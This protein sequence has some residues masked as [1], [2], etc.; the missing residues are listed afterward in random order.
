MISEKYRVVAKLRRN[1]ARQGYD[2]DIITGASDRRWQPPARAPCRIPLLVDPEDPSRRYPIASLRGDRRGPNG[3]T[4]YGLRLWENE[5]L[6]PRPDDVFQERLYC[7]RWVTPS[8]E[9][10]YK[11]VTDA[12][13]A[14]EAKV[15]ALLKQRF[16][17]W[18]A[19][20][21]IPS[22]KITPGYNT[23]Q[24]IRE[25]GWTY[26]H[27][28]F[29]PRQLLVHGLLMEGMGKLLSDDLRKH[30]LFS[31]STIKLEF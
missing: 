3:E 23:E 25:R 28:L 4:I 15:L 21:Y 22:M 9:R 16:A 11:S 24:P 19:R 2:I 7:V 27:H 14:R 26:W 8:G 10:V 20:G 29:N 13:I 17:D 12:D 6:V 1:D 5:D 18:Q 30:F 31:W